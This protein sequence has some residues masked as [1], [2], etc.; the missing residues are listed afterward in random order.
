MKPPI[1]SG[2]CSACQA[3]AE[4]GRSGVWWHA[5]QGQSCGRQDAR[6]EAL[7][8]EPQE[9]QQQAPPRDRQIRHPGRDR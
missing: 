5:S 3:P 4:R 2:R 6:F 8:D 9:R 7:P 1:E